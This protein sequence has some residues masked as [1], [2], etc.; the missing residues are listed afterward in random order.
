MRGSTARPAALW[1]M[2]LPPEQQGQNRLCAVSAHGVRVIF[3]DGS[4]RLDGSSGL[5]NVLLGYG[6]V[7]IAEAIGRCALNASYL[8]A[9]GHENTY[10]RAAAESLVELSGGRFERVFFSTSGGAC[11]D[12]ALKMVRQYQDLTGAGSKRLVLALEDGYHGLTYGAFSLTDAELGKKVYQVD[13]RTV[14]HIPANDVQALEKVLDRVGA[15]VAAV[16]VEPVLGTG[17]VPL[18]AGFIGTLL[19]ARAR[20]D[21]LLVA[22]EIS[23]GLGRTA[24]DMFDSLSWPQTPDLV[25]TGKALTNGVLPASAILVNARV[26][27]AFGRDGVVFA[28]AETQ[29]GSSVV[30]A[31]VQATVSEIRR[32]D[33]LG[34]ARRVS[35]RLDILL[36]RLVDE[37]PVVECVSGRGCMRALHLRTPEGGSYDGR[38]TVAAIDAVRE[39]GAMLHAGP[40]AVQLLPAVVY[41]DEDLDRLVERVADGLEVFTRRRL[42]S[43]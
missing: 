40:S 2:M 11:V 42:D 6:N 1:P 10:A 33:A 14:G 19:A 29:A 36:A 39:A 18:T 22:D 17:A 24:T 30:S 21:F 35:A 4:T 3:A 43:T 25:L 32:L 9:W 15:D 37:L 12:A 38:A 13:G 27:E 16:F 41:S 34:Q 31:A 8:T 26:A 28:H 23:T 5:W 20:Y 7:A